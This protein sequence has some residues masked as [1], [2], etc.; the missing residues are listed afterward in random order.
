MHGMWVK[1][2]RYHQWQTAFKGDFPEFY[3]QSVLIVLSDFQQR[4]S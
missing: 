4:V 1:E 3:G 2:A